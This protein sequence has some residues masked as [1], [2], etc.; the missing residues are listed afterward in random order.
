M[1]RPDTSNIFGVNSRCLV[2]VYVQENL[3]VSPHPWGVRKMYSSSHSRPTLTQQ[4]MVLCF[5]Y[6]SPLFLNI[7][8]CKVKK[9]TEYVILGGG[10]GRV[11]SCS[12]ER[13][14][15]LF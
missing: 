4:T 14:T 6:E 10:G 5:C 11:E 13:L 2:Q 7:L 15:S 12:I 1:P 9:Q 3:R 8:S